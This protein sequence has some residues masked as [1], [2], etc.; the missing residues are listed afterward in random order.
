M[1]PV[2]DKG[3]NGASPSGAASVPVHVAIIMDGNGRWANGRGLARSDGHRAGTENIRRIIRAFARHGVKHLT[4]YAFS[5]ENWE[6]PTDEVGAL[7][8]L[9]GEA[10]RNET[11]SLH[12]EGVRIRHL[13]RVDRLSPYLRRA[14]NESV[15]LTKHNKVINLNVAFDYGGREEVLQAVR[16][17]LRDGVRPD[18]VDE[19]L[20]ASRLYT[21][22]IPDPDLIIRTAGEMRLSNFLLWQ[23]AYAEYYTTPTL[24]PDFDEAEVERALA[25]YAHRQRRFGRVAPAEVR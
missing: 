15:E 25:A 3:A 12:K 1:T 7:M 20:L 4:L 18:E 16:T 8:E 21:A 11:E 17:M 9:M 6:R 23:A 19:E 22:G 24:W 13:G 5:T 2:P 10:I 14:I